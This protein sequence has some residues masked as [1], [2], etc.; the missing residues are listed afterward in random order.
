MRL[1]T[2]PARDPKIGW[3]IFPV[4]VVRGLDRYGVFPNETLRYAG[5]GFSSTG[6]M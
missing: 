2:F 1:R 4:G 6:K 5:R 3:S